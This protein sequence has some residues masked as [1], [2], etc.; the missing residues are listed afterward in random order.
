MGIRALLCRDANPMSWITSA[1][2]FLYRLCCWTLGNLWFHTHRTQN[3][4]SDGMPFPFCYWPCDLIEC[5]WQWHKHH[6]CQRQCQL[7]LYLI[8]W[9]ERKTNELS[10]WVDSF[11]FYSCSD[12]HR[13]TRTEIVNTLQL[14]NNNRISY[15]CN[16]IV[17]FTTNWKFWCCCIHCLFGVN[18]CQWL[19]YTHTFPFIPTW[20]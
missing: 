3:E 9:S 1:V 20:H 18:E 15:C 5:N 6:C 14:A 4:T 10:R 7:V 12:P 19:V 2:W 16:S 17:A 11:K 8:I 13:L